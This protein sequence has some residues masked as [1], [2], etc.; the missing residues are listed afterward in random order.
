M[1]LFF[2]IS[3]YKIF[4]QH[5]LWLSGSDLDIVSLCF[6]TVFRFSTMA[7]N[8]L[9][10]LKSGNNTEMECSQ[11]IHEIIEEGRPQ[12]SYVEKKQGT[13]RSLLWQ[14]CRERED[15]EPRL[16]PSLEA[17]GCRDRGKARSLG[18]GM[19]EKQ[20]RGSTVSRMLTFWQACWPW[21]LLE[22]HLE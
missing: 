19:E 20:I 2:N 21:I 18:I 16:I 22:G 4:T 14:Q 8:Y 17:W 5:K 13:K 1:N 11:V 9:E 12:D 15:S 10:K 3:S 7:T 6:S